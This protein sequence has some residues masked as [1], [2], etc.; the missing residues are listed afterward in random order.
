M[1][2]QQPR[3]EAPPHRD[4]LAVVEHLLLH[5]VH[6]ARGERFFRMFAR[7]EQRRVPGPRK[8]RASAP[9]AVGCLM[10]NPRRLRR[11]AH[12]AAIGKAAEESRLP[13]PRELHV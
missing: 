11:A 4:D 3:I 13:R 6:R 10:R 12:L 5:P 2:Q 8:V 9:H 7:D 1:R